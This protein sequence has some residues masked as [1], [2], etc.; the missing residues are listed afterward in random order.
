MTAFPVAHPLGDSAITVTF[1]SDSAA[2]TTERV[3]RI[4]GFLRGERIPHVEE[5]VAAYTALTVFYDSLHASYDELRTILI[6]KCADPRAADAAVIEP[7]E[8]R[9]P[10]NYSGPDLD[11]VAAATSLTTSEVIEIHSSRWYAVDLLGF[12]PGFAYLSELDSRLEL[13]RRD[14]P[15]PRVPAGS[16]AIA[17]RLTGIYP[18]DTPG[19]WHILGHTDVVLFDPRRDEPSLFRAGD[20]V[21]F[22]PQS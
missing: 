1:A 4:A 10:V 9:I 5:V 17:A 19:G 14:Q 12:V 8:H 13:P 20:R 18:F 16:V 22:E 2:E 7:R 11:A 6:A 21:R 15:R 3:R